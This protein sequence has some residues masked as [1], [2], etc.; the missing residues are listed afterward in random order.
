MPIHYN[1][2]TLLYPLILQG[3]LGIQRG[4]SY[5]LP[6][7]FFL[8]LLGTSRVRASSFEYTCRLQAYMLNFIFLS[9]I[10]LL[11]INRYDLFC[12]IVFD[13]GYD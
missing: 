6:N 10:L 11:L 1:E 13:L 4:I 12:Q 7:D 9:N 2:L 8:I 3:I 5:S